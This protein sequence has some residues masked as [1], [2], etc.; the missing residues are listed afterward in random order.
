M[1]SNMKKEILEAS[2]KNGTILGFNVFGFEDAKAVIEA[3][4]ELNYPVILMLNKLATKHLPIE[5]W[6]GLLLPLAQEAKIPVGVHLDHCQDFNTIVRA[7]KSGFT[8]VMFDGSQYPVEKNIELTKEIVKIAKC[9]NV[10][11]EGEIGSVP[12]ADIPDAAKDMITIPEE[13]E[14]F[15]KE[16][17]IDWMAIS[18]GNVHRL[19]KTKSRINFEKLEEIE[20]CT[21]L[22]LVIH[23]L[24]GIHE[25]DL[26]RIINSRIGKMNFGTGLRV[27]FGETLKKSIEENPELYDRL[28]LFENSQK[29]VKEE[30][31][32]ILELLKVKN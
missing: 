23:G 9:F 20:K 13:A 10:A 25:D 7:I 4:E 19:T 15:A 14:R 18:V 6:A 5:S 31:K 12:Y 21:D 3:A 28:I 8:S 17:G 11:V 29:A 30:A 24:S 22:P 26:P 27:A 16:S 1:L 32:R 2:K